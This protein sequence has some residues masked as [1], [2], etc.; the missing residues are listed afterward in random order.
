[1]QILQAYS[2][3]AARTLLYALTTEMQQLRREPKYVV[4]IINNARKIVKMNCQPKYRN[5]HK[6]WQKKC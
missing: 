6:F 2:T 3:V 5:K 4:T 1:V